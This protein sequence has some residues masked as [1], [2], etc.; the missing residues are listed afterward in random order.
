MCSMKWSDLHAKLYVQDLGNP[1]RMIAELKKPCL[2][3]LDFHARILWDMI[4][5]PL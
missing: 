5:F 3:V 2:S 4:P 1:T